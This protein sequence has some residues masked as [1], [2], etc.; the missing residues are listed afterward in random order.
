MASL[1]EPVV[2]NLKVQQYVH[3]LQVNIEKERGNFNAHLCL[4]VE[5]E[6]SFR[7]HLQAQTA[8]ESVRF[9]H[10]FAQCGTSL[11]TV[12]NRWVMCG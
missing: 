1:I 3:L 9:P 2:H 11:L 7:L 10:T 12:H 6:Q 4:Q 5:N 8:T